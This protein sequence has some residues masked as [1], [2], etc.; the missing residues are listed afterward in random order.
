MS[1]SVV[2]MQP[3]AP[4][5]QAAA[6][7]LEN[8]RARLGLCEAQL[9]KPG[10]HARL[11]GELLRVLGRQLVAMAARL[12]SREPAAGFAPSEY[13]VAPSFLPFEKSCHHRRTDDAPQNIECSLGSGIGC[14]SSFE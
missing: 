7:C 10:H 8:L 4:G 6:T 1:V 9:V 2:S 5:P 13:T 12:V 14:K 3:A 11:L